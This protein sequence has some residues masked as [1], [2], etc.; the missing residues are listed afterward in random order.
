MISLPDNIHLVFLGAG[1][2]EYKVRYADHP[3]GKRITFRA[4]VLPDQVVP[5]IKQADLGAVLYTGDSPN[6][7]HCLPNRFLHYIS[8]GLPVL[9]PLLPEITKIVEEYSLGI[10][11]DPEDEDSI[12]TALAK[13]I[14][15]VEFRKNLQRGSQRAASELCWENEKIKLYELLTSVL[16]SSLRLG[17]NQTSN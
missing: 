7:L 10:P 15:D 4:P 3:L 5:L 16:G 13:L 1:Y 6:M 2:D 11:I 12:R 17:S 14:G 8:A 9:Y